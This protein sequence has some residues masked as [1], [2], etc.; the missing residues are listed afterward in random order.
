ME[1][2]LAKK[3]IDWSIS[4]EAYRWSISTACL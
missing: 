2:H 3:H 4:T 1:I